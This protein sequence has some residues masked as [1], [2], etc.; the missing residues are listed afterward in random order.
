M[1]VHK[2]VSVLD[3]NLA[4]H[5]AVWGP[6]RGPFIHLQGMIGDM[7]PWSIFQAL[8]LIYGFTRARSI[9]AIQRGSISSMIEASNR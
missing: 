1:A 8:P 4:V 7:F 5:E 3:N 6:S 9:R 2:V